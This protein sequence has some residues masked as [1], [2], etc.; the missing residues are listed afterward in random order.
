MS[1]LP[2]YFKSVTSVLILALVFSVSW[3]PA[4]NQTAIVEGTVRDIQKRPLT[5]T[6]ILLDDQ[7]EGRSTSTTS[8]SQGHFRFTGVAAGTYLLRAKKSG[9]LDATEGPFAL[10]PSEN[11]SLQLKMMA[12][13][14]AVNTKDPS[15]A[16]A[17]SDEPQFTIAGVIDPSNVGG[18]SSNVTLPTKEA[19]AK[20]TA[21]LASESSYAK[22]PAETKASAEDSIRALLAAHDRA[23]LHEQLA[24][25]KES[26]GQPLE[27]VKEYQRAAEMETSEPY[28]FSWGAELLLHHADEQ[29]SEV[30]AKGHRLYPNSTRILVGLG[31]A[32]YAQDL[33]DQAARW[34]I[35]A[36]ELNPADPRP[37]WFLGKVQEVAKREPPEWAAAFERFATLQPNNAGAH[38]YYAVALE[39]QK[40]GTVDFAAREAHLKKTLELDPRF[41]DAYLR[42]GQ[43][44]AEKGE[45]N[46]AVTSLQKAIQYTRLPDEAHLRLAQVYRQMG[47]A[48]KARKESERYSEVSEEKRKLLERERRELGQFV[49]TMGTPAPAKEPSTNP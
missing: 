12:D 34:L 14:A 35:E 11:V 26:E 32:A 45:L 2:Q 40:R 19:L 7:V 46:K 16:I 27:A 20:E 29:A 18:H 1:N 30:F 41:G 5:D 17:Y 48:E 8:D 25:I 23:D 37:Y 39:K 36:I 10:K 42:V 28:L 47:Q 33:N 22:K 49:F 15:Q 3:L 31:A 43:L 24:E 9:Y 21:A 13:K 44:E 38:Y 6:K 4:Q